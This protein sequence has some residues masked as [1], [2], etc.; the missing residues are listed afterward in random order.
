MD[1]EQFSQLMM[2][3]AKDA[4]SFIEST[5]PQ[6]PDY[7]LNSLTLVDQLINSLNQQHLNE[8][9]L[10]T[11][12]YMLGAYAGEVYKKE[13]GGEW[14]FIDGSENEPPQTFFKNGERSI[15]FPGKIYHA[16]LGQEDVTISE[17]IQQL[18]ES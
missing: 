15:A 12:S 1:N 13:A 4:I 9:E 6:H 11:Y 14:V 17:Y 10:F 8:K 18:L 2:D 16:L 7:S 3:T 5:G